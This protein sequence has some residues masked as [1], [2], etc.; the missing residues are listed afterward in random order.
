MYFQLYMLMMAKRLLMCDLRFKS[1]HVKGS[2]TIKTERV[3][4][5]ISK[6]FGASSFKFL[7]N[8]IHV[9]YLLVRVLSSSLVEIVNFFFVLIF[10][11]C[12]FLEIQ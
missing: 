6:N 7:L 8:S 2:Y 1:R 11:F 4:K 12:F 10:S 3:K 9:G 5:S